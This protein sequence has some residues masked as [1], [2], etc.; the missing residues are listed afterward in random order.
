MNL[1]LRFR[2][3]YSSAGQWIDSI[4]VANVKSGSLAKRGGLAKGTEILAIQGHFVHGLSKEELG[5][6]L[7]QDEVKTIVLL[8]RDS[9]AGPQREVR[10]N[11]SSAE[12]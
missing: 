10:F 8:V 7:I 3:A 12:K 6:L 1:E 9:A 5:R 2:Y 11:F 4:K